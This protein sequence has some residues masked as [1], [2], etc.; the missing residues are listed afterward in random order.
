[1]PFEKKNRSVVERERER[2]RKGGEREGR[3]GRE[4]TRRGDWE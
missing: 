1:M 2:E 4:V 3:R